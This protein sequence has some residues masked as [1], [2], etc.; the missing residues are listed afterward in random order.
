ML[1]LDSLTN[2]SNFFCID[3]YSLGV[4]FYAEQKSYFGTKYQ[5]H[6]Q[7]SLKKVLL[8]SF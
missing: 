4:S 7:V 2:I 3:V 1:T 8:V 6:V 5:S